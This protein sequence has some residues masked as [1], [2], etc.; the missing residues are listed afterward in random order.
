MSHASDE[1]PMINS[2]SK[3]DQVDGKDITDPYWD[4]LLSSTS[5]PQPIGVHRALGE[6]LRSGAARAPQAH[7]QKLR[8]NAA[9]E[10]Q[11]PVTQEQKCNLSS[12]NTSAEVKNLGRRCEQ[13]LELGSSTSNGD[14]EAHGA[15]TRPAFYGDGGLVPRS[16]FLDLLRGRLRPNRVARMETV[17][18]QRCERVT[19]L[20]ENLAHPHNGA[21][22]L[23][24]C[25]CFGIQYIHV[26]ES[27][28]VFRCHSPTVPDD[29]WSTRSVSRSCDQ[30]L[31]I[32][33][34]HR[35]DECMACLRAGGYQIVGTTLDAERSLPIDA[36]DLGTIPRICIVLGNEERGLS[37][38]MQRHCD[39][40][41]HLPMLG[42][43]Q[44][45]NVS[46]AAGCILYHLRMA[47]CIQADLKPEQMRELYTRWLVRANRNTRRVLERNGID[48]D[49]I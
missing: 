17:L 21:A 8:L 1:T 16:F 28:E 42:F 29:G 43:S 11:G 45:L 27:I 47:G 10:K 37:A 44:S 2:D 9:R 35:M 6:P 7:S 5:V 3:N 33:R 41:V 12:K 36:V 13:A 49:E 34:F 31:H 32:R 26:L 48:Y 19:V 14:L 15:D 20:L 38:A 30:W 4:A 40:L 18:R 22:I 24:T 46:V 25:E 39:M 23:R